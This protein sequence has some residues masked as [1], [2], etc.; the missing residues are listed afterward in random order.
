MADW[1]GVSDTNP[2]NDGLSAGGTC[3]RVAVPHPTMVMTAK[4]MTTLMPIVVLMAGLIPF[5]Q[6]GIGPS[7]PVD[8]RRES[9]SRTATAIYDARKIRAPRCCRVR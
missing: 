5:H 9:R 1:D 3:A 2:V 8:A 6:K 4:A 7:L